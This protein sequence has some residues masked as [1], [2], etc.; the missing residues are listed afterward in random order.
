[1]KQGIHPNYNSENVIKCTSCGT[2]Y[3]IGSA[4]EGLTVAICAKCHPF[5]TGEQQ[6]VVDTANKISSFKERVDKASELKKRQ[7]EIEKQRA[8]R[9]KT[10]VGVIGNEAKLTLRDLLKANQEKKSAK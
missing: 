9:A 5:Y 2:S 1:M 10:K 7:A 6:V 4:K 3:E 8:E